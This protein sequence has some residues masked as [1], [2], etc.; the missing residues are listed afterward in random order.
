MRG[1]PEWKSGVEGFDT[2]PDP[3]GQSLELHIST[4]CGPSGIHAVVPPVTRGIWVN[5]LGVMIVKYFSLLFMLCFLPLQAN[6]QVTN[7]EAEGNLAPTHKVGCIPLKDTR[8]EYTP[9]DLAVAVVKCT[10]NKN[11]DTAVD[12]FILMQLRAVYDTKRVKDR[13]AHQAGSVLATQ[14]RNA[15]GPARLEKMQEALD[16]FGGN[17][18]P[19]HKA[20][21]ALMKRQGPPKYHPTYM[22]QHGMSAFT[23]REGNGLIRKFRPQKAWPDLLK[24]YM[25]CL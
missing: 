16:K 3:A 14:I 19:R 22:I 25:K 23:G 12:L 18:S 15:L 1:A 9:A 13:T 10:D 24:N 6:S 8:P 21:C 5:T 7:Y 2:Q 4:N 11:Y 17:N 20:F